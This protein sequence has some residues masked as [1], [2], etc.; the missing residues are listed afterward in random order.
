MAKVLTQYKLI[1]LYMLDKVDFPLTNTQ[2]ASFIL[3]KEYT[4]YFTFQQAISNLVDAQL[5][6]TES[7]HSNTRYHITPAGKET[8]SYFPDKISEAIKEDIRSFFI[9]NKIELRKETIALADYYK[10]STN[11]YAARCQIKNAKSSL[12]DLIITVKS[13]KQAEAI[14]ENW[15]EQNEVIFGYLMDT[16]VK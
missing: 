5:I 10:T 8:L 13:K 2:I 12:I 14:C 1:I 16:L 4:T 3:E 15:R 7:T 11:A 9:T 6:T